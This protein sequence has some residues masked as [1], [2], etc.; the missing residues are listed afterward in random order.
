MKALMDS[1]NERASMPNRVKYESEMW[2][3]SPPLH[4][5]VP[6]SLPPNTTL[7]DRRRLTRLEN[8]QKEHAAVRLALQEQ[9]PEVQKGIE[10][11]AKKARVSLSPVDSGDRPTA[12]ATVCLG[13]SHGLSF[14]LMSG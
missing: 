5:D 6:S 9:S 1:H 10:S 14:A 11:A 4:Y 7:A 2:H 3:I 8:D 13:R 12:T